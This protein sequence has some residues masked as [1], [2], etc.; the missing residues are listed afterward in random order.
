MT[1]AEIREIF[2]QAQKRDEKV[3]AWARNLI[4]LAAGSLSVLVSLLQGVPPLL[5]K[6]ALSFL[7]LGILLGALFLYGEIWKA[8]EMVKR[9][10]EQRKTQSCHDADRPS[11]IVARPPWWI[12]RAEKACY[13]ALALAVAF[14]VAHIA[15]L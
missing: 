6:L 14:L 7:A 13:A 3:Y 12:E 9:L 8:R 11:P 4:L 2:E 10:V 15:L 1:E 5:L